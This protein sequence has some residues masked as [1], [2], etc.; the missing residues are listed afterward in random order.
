MT[1][2]IFVFGL[3]DFNREKLKSVR[4]ADSLRFHQL[5]RTDQVHGAKKFDF[6]GL[7][8][9]ADRQLQSAKGNV[10]GVMTFWDFPT[11]LLHPVLCEKYGLPGPTSQS[12][13]LATQKY[14]SRLLQSQVVPEHV[15]AFD[16]LDPFDEDAAEGVSLE[17]PFWVKPVQSYSGFLAY[18]V[19]DQDELEDHLREVRSKIDRYAHPFDQ[20]RPYLQGPKGAEHV[21]ARWCLAEEPV[22][23]HQC[24][25]EG[26]VYEGEAQ[27]YGVVDTY[28]YPNGVSFHR[29]QYPTLLQDHVV[30]KIDKASRKV[31]EHLG[32]DMAAF[33]IEWFWD[34]DNGDLKILEINSRISQSHSD[35]F[36][37]VDGCSNHEI[38]VELS[39]GNRPHLDRCEGDYEMAAEVYIRNFQDGVVQRV[40]T[41]QEIRWIEQ[42]VPGSTIKLCVDR[43]MRLSQILDQDS[44]SYRLAYS[45]IGGKDEKEILD[46]AEKIEKAL[47]FE[48]TTI[49]SRREITRG[50]VYGRE[51]S[52]GPSMFAQGSR[53]EGRRDIPRS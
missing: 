28:R 33:N 1:Q 22:K 53:K 32:Y 43:G 34:S 4:R 42:R 16:V 14:W 25:V 48:V 31:M 18:L 10:D 5:L 13:G 45:Y 24:T 9:E 17:Y 19:H 15:P 27:T 37:K 6:D 50:V 46:K 40:P 21:D 49:P 26:F 38:P 36:E 2:D 44:Y 39:L 11:N 52:R 29:Y 23:G 20:A 8:T 47:P 3:D 30:D 12:V 41:R 35:L 51:G 7:L